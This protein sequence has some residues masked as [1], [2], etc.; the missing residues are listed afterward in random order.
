MKQR[1]IVA[2]AGKVTGTVAR[3]L[4]VAVRVTTG[5]AVVALVGLSLSGLA[6]GQ[7]RSAN[8]PP[9]TGPASSANDSSLAVLLEKGIYTEETAG[10]LDG[11]IKVYQQIIKD[12]KANQPF[13]AQAQYR[14]AMC[15]LKKGDKA[16]AI[17][18]LQSLV[19]AYPKERKVVAQARQ[20]L[21]KLVPSH[22]PRVIKTTP[23]M[24]ANDVDPSLNKITVT[25]DRP[26]RDKSWSFTLGDKAFYENTGSQFPETIGEISYDAKGITCTMPVKLQPGKVYWLGINGPNFQNFRSADGVPAEQ[27]IILFATKTIDGKPTPLSDKLAELATESSSR[28][29]LLAYGASSD[30]DNKVE[31]KAISEIKEIKSFDGHMIKGKLTLPGGSGKI[32]KLVIW[33]IGS[34]PHTYDD[35]RHLMG[36]SKY[37]FFDFFAEQFSE[38]G[39]A[40]F[41]YNTR[42]VDVVDQPPLFMKIDEE[43]YKTYL[44]SNCVEDIFYMIKAIKENER[45]KDCKVLLLGWSEGTIIAPLFAKKYPGMVDALF[46]CSYVNDNV[47]D[48]LIWEKSGGASMVWYRDKFVA[49]AQGRISKAAYEADPNNVVAS[50]LQ[51]ITFE[52]ID[53]NHDGYIDES[54]FVIRMKSSREAILNAIVR[55]DNEWLKK[56]YP[57]RLTAEWFLEHFSLGS[58]MELL[59]ELNLPIYIFNGAFD[60]GRDV[61]GVYK[62]KDRFAEL[63]KTN[64]TAHVFD[65][66]D[67]NLN[68]NDIFSRNEI[69]VGIQSLLDTINNFKLIEPVS[70][71]PVKVPSA[72]DKKAA[73]SL[74]AQG[75]QLW[76]QQKFAEAEEKF[77]VATAKDPTVANTWNGLGWAQFNQGKKTEAKES[78]ERALKIEPK[79]AACLNGLGWIAKSQGESDQAIEYWEKAVAVDPNAT[80]ARNG[81]ATIYAERGLYDQAIKQYDAWLQADPKD[82]SVRERLQEAKENDQKLLKDVK[83]WLEL[84]D[85]GEYDQAWKTAGETM[86]KMVSDKD[87]W[88]KAIQGPR[89]AM[90]KVESRKLSSRQF[91]K[92]LPVVN[93]EG[94]FLVLVYDTKFEKKRMY[95]NV[96]LQKPSSKLSIVGYTLAPFTEVSSAQDVPVETLKAAEQWL[97]LVDDGHY[98]ESWKQSAETFQKAVGQ[99]KWETM[100]KEVRTPMGELKTR[101]L[102]G[103]VNVPSSLPS[104]ANSSTKVADAA[105]IAMVLQFEASYANH[106]KAIETVSLEKDK[107]GQWRVNGYYIK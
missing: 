11:A 52:S 65:K 73:E 9:T 89:E 91:M 44:P 80:A 4:G 72:A 90:G 81:L 88:G 67:H 75:W 102:M 83:N 17:Q 27:S 23:M 48:V 38:N 10:D 30:K 36:G 63:G 8:R 98:A 54:D 100:V 51:N 101:K 16:K 21:A 86:Q 82:P 37:N 78:F 15:Y 104:G 45:L 33:I 69:S 84:L 5:V 87:L 107:T 25:F 18:E 47:K 77:K 70:S 32:S 85:R 19:E 97:K 74:S 95:E 1:A 94:P 34:G 42:G 59:P 13:A 46:L 3:T 57:V 31:E 24:F 79:Q 14:L 66:H 22:V 105:T 6:W 64:L 41:S 50:V 7:E 96:V 61:N 68:V 49:D 103:Q 58:N 26:M 2:A 43:G 29:S 92:T 55:K 106:E 12:A 60:Q 62:I 20:E 76:Q 99:Q 93:I 39:T 56:N 71:Q 40:F 35:R 28:F 53:A